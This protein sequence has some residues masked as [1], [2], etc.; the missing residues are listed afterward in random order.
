MMIFDC[1]HSETMYRSAS[2]SEEEVQSQPFTMQ[3]L[4]D[5]VL[6]QDS[7]K[8]VLVWSGCPDNDYSYGDSTGGVL[9]LGIKNAYESDRTYD[10][11]WT[12]ASKHAS[13]QHPKKTEIGDWPNIS[14]FR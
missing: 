14:V 9:T 11:V 12:I 5:I 1:C 8:K 3:M 6:P 13:S 4:D 7:D 10:K 2:L